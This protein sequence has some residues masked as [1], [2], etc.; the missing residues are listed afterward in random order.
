[1]RVLVACDSFGGTL[2]AVGAT[3]AIAEGWQRRAPV[4][5]LILAPMSDGGPGFV[6]ALHASLPGEL[7]AVTATDLYGDEIPAAVLIVDDTAYIEAAQVC[8][9]HLS[10]SRDPERASSYGV[11]QLVGAAIDEGALRVVVGLGGVGS[12]DAG[13]GMLAALG[14]RAAPAG[15]LRGGPSG[16]ELLER[17]DLSPAR[18]RCADVELVVA[19]DVDTPL[20]GLRGTTNLYGRDKG[21][22]P[23]RLH[24]VD[25]Q[26]QRLA[27][28]TDQR[29]ASRSGSGAGGG[30]G[31][32]LMLLGG[33]HFDGVGLVADTVGLPALAR[34]AD[35]V[36]TGEAVFDFSSR[37]RKV[38]L[39]VARIA[40]DAIRPCVALAGQVFVGAREM[41][42]LGIEAAYSVVDTVGRDAA[43]ADPAVSLSALAER[44]ARTW[45]H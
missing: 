1:M 6:D 32:G 36:V 40:R 45:S 13:A 31:F 42:A 11:G 39:G 29:A 19:S 41:R 27:T 24:H 16:L 35:L 7:L 10:E 18:E 43:F 17:I 30:L 33:A 2:T 5:D 38:P 23:D 14:S 9:L 44:V 34:S 4:D 28:A 22:D 15:A 25:A 37:S 20:L 21:V 26:L 3:A 8:G 12:N